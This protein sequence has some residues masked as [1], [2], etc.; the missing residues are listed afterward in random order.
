MG[1]FEIW[2]RPVDKFFHFHL[3]N[4]SANSEG[5]AL[6]RYLRQKMNP[7]EWTTGLSGLTLATQIFP[8]GYQLYD[9][10]YA[11][12]VENVEMPDVTSTL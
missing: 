10:D 8:R 4:K 1:G 7:T 12:P 9:S 11:C 2:R 6:I 3:S 5:R